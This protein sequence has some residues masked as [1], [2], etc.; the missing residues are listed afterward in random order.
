[1]CSLKLVYIL[2]FLVLKPEYPGQ[3][4]SVSWLLMPWHLAS[5][6]HQLSW[7]RP[8]R[9]KG[10]LSSVRKDFQ[11]LGACLCWEMIENAKRFIGLCWVKLSWNISISCYICS[12]YYQLWYVVKN[13]PTSIVFQMPTYPCQKMVISNTSFLYR[14][15]TGNYSKRKCLDDSHL[16]HMQCGTVITRSILLNNLIT[17]TP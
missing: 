8:C 10:S 5:P 12:C 14:K 4:R 6:G 13:M 17:D 15:F 11:V 9:I 7:Y 1:M 2:S 16:L 3:S